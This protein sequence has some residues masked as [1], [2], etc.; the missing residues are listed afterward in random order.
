ME[1]SNLEVLKPEPVKGRGMLNNIKRVLRAG[2]FVGAAAISQMPTSV[3]AQYIDPA[4]DDTTSWSQPHS[5]YDNTY[6]HTYPDYST[7]G[8]SDAG[9]WKAP[10]SYVETEKN[11]EQQEKIRGVL[12]ASAEAIQEIILGKQSAPLLTEDP[13]KYLQRTSYLLAKSLPNQEA[14]N[15]LSPEQLKALSTSVTDI[16]SWL[17]KSNLI[18]D[19]S[20]LNIPKE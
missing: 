7:P 15:S 19:E 12:K 16:L 9:S 5:S 14:L 1:K 4:T 18:K 3:Q 2:T 6:T 20:F 10:G 17:R 8:Y 13:V 11:A